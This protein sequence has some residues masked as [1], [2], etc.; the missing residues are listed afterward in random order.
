MKNENFKKYG[1]SHADIFSEI[2]AEKF[3]GNGKNIHAEGLALECSFCKPCGIAVG[4]DNVVF[5]TDIDT[6]RVNVITPLINTS[7]FLKYVRN[8]YKAFSIHNKGDRYELQTVKDAANTVNNFESYLSTLTQNIRSKVNKKLSK[9][10]NGPEVSVAGVTM[11]SVQLIS[12]GLNR[13]NEITEDYSYRN[14]NLLS[15]LT[16]NVEHFHSSTHFKSTVLSMQQYCRQ[17]GSTVKE[18]IK[19]ISKWSARYYTGKYWYQPQDDAI[20]LKDMPLFENKTIKKL[21]QSKIEIRGCSIITSS[22]WDGWV[23]AFFVILRTKTR[24]CVWYFMKGRNVTVKKIKK[25][26]FILL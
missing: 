15:C 19:E 5:I 24:V 12:S 9:H 7:E 17:F 1:S 18:S 25:P 2:F 22:M 3:T 20:N 4:F 16:L 8:F 26:F 6:N 10:L 21:E 14:V 13:L 23:S 11:K